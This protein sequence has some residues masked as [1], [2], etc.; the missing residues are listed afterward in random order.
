[1][2]IRTALRAIAALSIA[3]IPMATLSTPAFATSSIVFFTNASY[4]DIDQEDVD[5][6]AAIEELGT[7]T[8]FDGGDGSASAWETA[9]AGADALVFPELDCD[10]ECD[11]LLGTSVLSNEAADVIAEFA[12]AGHT[13]IFTGAYTHQGL[14]DDLT[15]VS[16]TWGNSNVDE[17]W[18]LD[19]ASDTLPESISRANYS[20]GISNWQ[21]WTLDERVGVTPIYINAERDNVGVAAFSVG[22][23]YL[24]YYAYDWY[25]DGDELVDGTRDAWDEALRLGA[26]GEFSSAVEETAGDINIGISL[27]L[28]VGDPVEGASA[29]A[30]ATGLKS[31]TDWT[32][33]LRSTPIVLDEGIVG[34]AGAIL[35]S[36]TIPAGLEP[37]THTLTVVGTASDGTVYQRVLTFVIAGDGTL[38]SEPI[39]G[40]L[41]PVTLASTGV[42]TSPVGLAALAFIAAGGI[43]LA[44]RRRKA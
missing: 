33:T 41:E 16:R 42:E 17:E 39:L 13:V 31:D 30:E 23:G 35:A 3:A 18:L 24:L 14:I 32:L 11:G 2:K 12:A 37:G 20:G 5:M 7:V 26:G 38:E 27:D 36:V 8:D 34:D 10:E 19:I 9:L 28:A 43:A 6:K 21:D 1:M 22:D 29:F 15:G 25:P 44:V 4:T 40:D